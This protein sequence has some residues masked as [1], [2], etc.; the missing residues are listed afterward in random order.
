MGKMR[1]GGVRRKPLLLGLYVAAP[2]KIGG[3]HGCSFFRKQTN[4][5]EA[6]PCTDS[7]MLMIFV[8]VLRYEAVDE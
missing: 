4:M 2:Q 1:W 3:S 6:T 8:N 5:F 7:P